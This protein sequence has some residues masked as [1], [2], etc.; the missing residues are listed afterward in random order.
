MKNLSKIVFALFLSFTFAN[1][2]FA[3]LGIKIGTSAQVG[4][5]DVGGS[6]SENG[7]IQKRSEE[8]PFGT[9]SFFIEKDL[10]FL[11]GPLG[12]LGVG[13]DY[14]PHNLATGTAE[15]IREDSKNGDVVN[16]QT[17]TMVNK[18]KADVD[19]IDT[20]YVTLR[21][22]DWLYAKAGSV[23]MDVVTKEDLETGSA[24]GNASLDGNMMG[25]GIHKVATDGRMFFRVEGNW[26]DI[27]G[28]TLTST[29]NTANKVTL[30]A[31]DTASLK[32]S[33][34]IQF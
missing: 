26:M 24:Y 14:V 11:P 28:I 4:L 10:N 27:D 33:I 2:S 22:T 20:L 29:T 21:I 7:S 18:V 1:I 25:I 12:R 17:R 30:D 5:A 15:N 16:N 8:V 3:D 34:G 6:E 19:N 31:I 13:Y 23:S 32:A 9:Y